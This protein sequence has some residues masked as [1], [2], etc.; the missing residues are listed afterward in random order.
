MS[1]SPR[2]PTRTCF[3]V[4]YS[5]Y[6]ARVAKP[7]RTRS[8]DPGAV[9]TGCSNSRRRRRYRRTSYCSL[10]AAP[11]PL[12]CQLRA[13]LGVSPGTPQELPPQDSRRRARAPEAGSRGRR[14]S[15]DHQCVAALDRRHLL[16]SQ[17][18]EVPLKR[19]PQLQRDGLQAEA[20][21]ANDTDL[22]RLSELGWAA[23]DADR[24]ECVD[25]ATRSK[26]PRALHLADHRELIAAWGL[27]QDRH[28]RHDVL[29]LRT[30]ASRDDP[31]NVRG[32]L[33][34]RHD[35]PDQRKTEG[36]IREDPDHA[37]QPVV[38]P[39]RDFEIVAWVDP[40][41]GPRNS[42]RTGLL[43]HKCNSKQR[44]EERE[45][46]VCHAGNPPWRTEAAQLPKGEP[47]APLQMSNNQ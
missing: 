12:R 24:L 25:I 27:Y 38:A 10:S 4:R 14:C 36:A 46:S 17:L 26:G 29:V 41:S 39:D 2:T 9:T 45:N 34:G 13:S 28:L 11:L 16:C 18:I 32:K 31:L 6:G 8:T 21:F 22:I 7:A 44:A 42:L 15:R 43:W 23:G 40:V 1:C 37:L 47:F 35:C 30:K 33:A 19:G 3:R 5:S 20:D